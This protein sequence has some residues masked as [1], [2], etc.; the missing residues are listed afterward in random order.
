MSERRQCFV[1]L[2]IAKG[3]P[4]ITKKQVD[5]VRPEWAA[6]V[7]VVTE[8]PHPGARFFSSQELMQEWL[9]A[10]NAQRA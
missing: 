2:T 3:A 10:Q 7:V 6:A 1:S 4:H 9:T 5:A 8:G